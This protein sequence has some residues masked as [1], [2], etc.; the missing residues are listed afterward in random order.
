MK[1]MTLNYSYLRELEHLVLDT[2]LPVY[3]K[4][5]ISRG[6]K[7]PLKDINPE[8]LKQIKAKKQVCALLRTYEK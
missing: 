4:Y 5:E 8:L 1:L 3:E 7:N 2:L 6:S